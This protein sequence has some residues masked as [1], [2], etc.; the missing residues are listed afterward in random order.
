VRG[1]CP[2]CGNAYE[3]EHIA[4]RHAPTTLNIVV[5][6]GWPLALYATTTAL[7]LALLTHYDDLVI[8]LIYVAA[9]AL[10]ACALNIPVQI[11]L[12][13]RKYG[14]PV[15][16]ATNQYVGWM[17]ILSVISI[18]GAFVVFGGCLTFIM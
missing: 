9:F 8:V 14:K 7:G 12:V 18:V 2:E 10:A 5:R 16:G 11:W 4:L 17:I 15:K 13:R 6:F 3:P 1:G